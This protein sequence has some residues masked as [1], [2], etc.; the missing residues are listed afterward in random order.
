MIPPAGC[1]LLPEETYTPVVLDPER[2]LGEQVL[3]V[4]TDPNPPAVRPPFWR[5]SDPPYGCGLVKETD[6]FTFE[7]APQGVGGGKDLCNECRATAVKRDKQRALANQITNTVKQL[8]GQ[9][10]A[11]D[12]PPDVTDMW[13]SAVKRHGGVD[14]FVNRIFDNIDK[15]EE[16][17]KI[18]TATN[19][20]I[21]VGKWGIASTEHQERLKAVQELDDDELLAE[22]AKTQQVIIQQIT[23][24]VVHHHHAAGVE[25]PPPVTLLEAT[26]DAPA[27]ASI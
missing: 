26:N 5:C 25:P 16:A 10:T 14:G 13:K 15:L 27:D 20:L 9:R 19:A 4:M 18:P 2:P 1:N 3:A 17:G 12:K 6:H 22:R 24:N 7:P 21:S 11:A 8:S 23:H